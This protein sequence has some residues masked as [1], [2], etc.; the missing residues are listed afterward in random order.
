[1]H[2]GVLPD[3]VRAKER[4]DLWLCL[5]QGNEFTTVCIQFRTQEPMMKHEASQ[6][7][8]KF[9]NILANNT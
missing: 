5:D 8:L 9:N 4:V 6:S 3:K 7:N 1:M 2:P